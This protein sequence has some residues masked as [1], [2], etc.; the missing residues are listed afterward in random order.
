MVKSC[1]VCCLTKIWYCWWHSR[2][3]S[4]AHLQLSHPEH[5]LT[6]CQTFHL[7]YIYWIYYDG[8]I[9]SSEILQHKGRNG[10]CSTR[11]Q[12]NIKQ[13]CPK[14]GDL[15]LSENLSWM[16]YSSTNVDSARS[17]ARARPAALFKHSWCSSSGL[18]SATIPAPAW[19]WATH[20]WRAFLSV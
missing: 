8:L 18:L 16:I 13:S 15:F 12:Q 10:F 1:L 11:K 3:R 17:M 9:Q 19:R 14:L 20:S 6:S 2:T 4:T 5:R 7:L